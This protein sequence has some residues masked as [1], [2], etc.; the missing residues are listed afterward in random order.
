[1]SEADAIWILISALLVLVLQSG[2]LCLESGTVRAKNAANVALKNL[3]DVCV[4]STAFWLTGF[5]LMFGPSFGGLFGVGGFWPRLD[6]AAGHSAAIFLFQMAFASTAATIV[7]GAVA[8]R[9]R[10]LGYMV[11]SVMLGAFIY[12]VAGH[13]VWNDAG[14]LRQAGFIDFAGATVVHSVGG[15]TALVAVVFLGPRLGRYGPKKRFFEENSISLVT[16]GGL[17]L[18]VGWGAFNGGSALAFSSDV[19]PV[20]A[21]T[22][23]SAAGAGIASIAIG[24]G[25]FR[26]VRAEI[27]VNGFLGGLVAGTAGIHLVTG[28]MAFVIGIAGSVTV[29]VARDILDALKI[30]DV[31]GAVPVH[32]AAGLVGTLAV[33]FTVPLELL[34]AGSR[35]GQL[36]VQAM[37]AAAVAAWVICCT[38]PLAVCLKAAGLLRAHPKDEVRGLNLAENNQRNALLELLEEMKQ[39]QRSGSFSRRVRVER[40]SELGALA[41]RYNRVL[42][43]VEDE[44]SLRVESIR[45]ERMSRELAEEAFEAMREA[46]EESAWSARHDKLTGLGNR[47][48]LEEIAAAPAAEQQA[49]TL[50]IALDLDRFKEIN[51]TYG[52]EAGDLVL[53]HAAK[54]IS[55]LIKNGRDFA[56][57]IGGD[58]FAVLMEFSGSEAEANE[59]CCDLLFA[60]LQPVTYKDTGLQVGASIGFAICAPEEPLLS[61]LRR[62]DLALYASKADGRSCVNAYSASIGSAHDEKMD[63]I[64]DFKQAFEKNEIEVTF[65]PQVDGKTGALAGCEA[66]AR[67]NH[68]RRGVVGP[69]VFVPIAKEVNMLAELDRRVLDIALSAY[70]EFARQ[71]VVLPSISVNVSA[72]R[73]GH[74]GLIEE[75]KQRTDIPSSGLAFEL[76]E[77]VFL[78]HVSDGYT[79]QI[80]AIKAMGIG[81]EIDDFGTGHASIAG[82]LALKPDRLKIDRMFTTGIDKKPVRRD[83]MR[84]LIEMA[85]SAGAV[86]VV[87][88]V[89]TAGEAEVLSGIGAAILQGYAF[90]RPMNSTRFMAWAREWQAEHWPLQA[91]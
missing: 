23:L 66:L 60:L 62:A 63:L 42:D 85:S 90:G 75:L 31:V 57:R 74:P 71:G 82:V 41:F 78:D 10:F 79:K 26:C 67:W 15:W 1:M 6:N 44:I 19:G 27:L 88:G 33:A 20:I 12:P 61:A 59:F 29:I 55:S 46:Q 50:V 47:K 28:P 64:R 21:R 84:G 72:E 83:L 53:E 32:L 16:L 73:L 91:G 35:L 56:F 2:F 34:P 49:G 24:L 25:L 68:P 89:E 87:E 30:D 11:M 81:I 65:Q 76:L 13:W 39:H 58:E 43:R 70:W 54:R 48:H 45:K 4:V 51:D 38:A 40:S 7:S 18:W 22:M 8:E 77:T 14:W 3:S 52:H 17:L 36:G 5:G 37:G 86:A 80:N 9:E 69:D